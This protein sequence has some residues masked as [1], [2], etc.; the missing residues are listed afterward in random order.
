MNWLG[1]AACAAKHNSRQH[2]RAIQDLIAV[3][4][5]QRDRE[6]GE[7]VGDAQ[8]AAFMALAGQHVHIAAF[9][10]ELSRRP[11]PSRRAARRRRLP[12]AA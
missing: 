12:S 2:A 3:G 6:G 5:Q 4:D 8:P 10:R 9:E 11:R 7:Q 1:S